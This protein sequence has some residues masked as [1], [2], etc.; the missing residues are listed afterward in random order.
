[1]PPP[2]PPSAE[3]APPVS[4]VE[5]RSPPP[6]E[7]PGQLRQKSVKGAETAIILNFPSP[8]RPPRQRADAIQVL[9]DPTREE[10]A[11][12]RVTLAA[13]RAM[14]SLEQVQQL[15][16]HEGLLRQYS[17]LLE[18]YFEPQR[19][20][21][22]AGLDDDE[23]ARRILVTRKLALDTL[24]PTERD[25]LSG[26]IRTLTNAIQQTIAL[27]RTVVGLGKVKTGT[28]GVEPSD[29]L[30][31]EGD[32]P[33]LVDPESMTTEQLRTIQHAM[34]LLDR[35]QHAMRDPPMPPPPDPLDDLMDLPP[36]PDEPDEPDEPELPPR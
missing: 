30:A 18:V 14:M 13:I 34:E 36:E 12:L 33:P 17:H 16:H 15:E 20:V 28:G 19:F 1:V 11:R 22:L 10:R 29:P 7:A 3:A 6:P 8:A 24:L 2:D 26:T 9:P 21:D 31:D 32:K 5:P 27:K 35:H 25:T 4:P 23:K